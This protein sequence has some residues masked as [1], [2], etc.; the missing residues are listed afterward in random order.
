MVAFN[1][2][3][4]L[5]FNEQYSLLKQEEYRFLWIASDKYTVCKA[6]AN[7]N[8]VDYKHTKLWKNSIEISKFSGEALGITEG[9]NLTQ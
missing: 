9:L 6:H 4:W 5:D 1:K 7:N 3:S 2:L 8:T